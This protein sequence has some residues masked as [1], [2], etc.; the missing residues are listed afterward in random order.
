MFN[1]RVFTQVL[2]GNEG[3]VRAIFESIERDVRHR[4]IAVVATNQIAHRIF[5]SSRMVYVGTSDAAKVYY[6]DYVAGREDWKAF[7]GPE[8]IE[9]CLE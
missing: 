3:D 7:M 6:K 4:D 9:V 8:I 1:E 2:E 5:A